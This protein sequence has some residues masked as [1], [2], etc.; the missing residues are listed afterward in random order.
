MA[1][2]IYMIHCYSPDRNQKVNDFYYAQDFYNNAPW[3][4]LVMCQAVGHIFG[5][6]HQDETFDNA[7][8]GT[9]MD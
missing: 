8:L 5:L 1:E 3:R 6:A 2:V 9:C 4:Q 7:N